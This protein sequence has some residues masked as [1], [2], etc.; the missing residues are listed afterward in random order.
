MEESPKLFYFDYELNNIKHSLYK[1]IL[2]VYYY[3]PFPYSTVSSELKMILIEVRYE[4]ISLRNS[5]WDGVYVLEKYVDDF[6][7]DNDLL[8]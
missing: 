5:I 3:S 8:K 2:K 1:D 7:K 6:L 4:R